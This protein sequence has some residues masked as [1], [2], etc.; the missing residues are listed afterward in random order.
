MEKWLFDFDDFMNKNVI[1]TSSSG[2]VLSGLFS[3]YTDDDI[4]LLVE[5]EYI[6][7]PV[8]PIRTIKIIE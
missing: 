2:D 4:E 1:V 8:E 3:D 5:G 6:T 7:I